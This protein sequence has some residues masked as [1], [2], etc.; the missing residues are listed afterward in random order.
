MTKAPSHWQHLLSTSTPAKVVAIV[1]GWVVLPL[2]TTPIAAAQANNR[3][4]TTEW[5]FDQVDVQ[6]MNL[7]LHRLGLGVPIEMQG[8]VSVD[9]TVSVPW[10]ALTDA[11]SYRI[12]GM[13]RSD[14]LR[15]EKLVIDDF[16][17][18]L[19]LSNGVMSIENLRGR[20]VDGSSKRPITAKGEVTGQANLQLSPLGSIEV[21][22]TTSEIP[23]LPLHD[24]VLAASRTSSEVQIAPTQLAST[25]AQKQLSG[26]ATGSLHFRAPLNQLQN[27]AA[28]TTTANLEINGLS[29][30]GS[31]PL[32]LST[33]AIS[34]D[35]GILTADRM[36]L[37]SP[38][39]AELTATVR[40][41]VELNEQQRFSAAIRSNDLPLGVLSNLFGFDQDRLAKGTL[42]IDA[43]AS[44]TLSRR[45]W[46]ASGRVASP[47]LEVVGVSLGLLEHEFSF[48]H[49]HFRL[50]PA[51]IPNTAEVPERV[52]ES[53]EADY[54]LRDQQW[55]LSKLAACVFGGEVT[56]KATLAL[57][58]LGTHQLDL[59]WSE[60]SPV[61]N[62]N[63]LSLAKVSITGISS[64]EIRWTVPAGQWDLPAKQDGMLEIAVSSIK[65]GGAEVGD[66]RMSVVNRDQ[67]LQ[68][69]AEG[70]LF[71]GDVTVITTAAITEK[72]TW[73]DLMRNPINAR[74]SANSIQLD[75][76][77][78]VLP[79]SVLPDSRYDRLKGRLTAEA[80]LTAPLQSVSSEQVEADLQLRL[81]N[82]A[83]GPVQ[84][85]NGLEISARLRDQIVWID[86]ISGTYA[87]GRIE[88]TGRWDWK[89]Q[90]GP[91]G[92]GRLELRVAAIDA[93]QAM[94]LISKSLAESIDGTLSGNL[95]VTGGEQLRARGAVQTSDAS[96]KGLMLGNVHSGVIA[97]YTV[98]S[99]RWEVGLI[100]I[101]GTL[102]RGRVRGKA[103]FDSAY[104]P[105]RFDM[106]TELG[107][108]RVDFN[109]LIAEAGGGVSTMAQGQ[110][111]GSLVLGGKSIA[112]LSDLRGSF[113][114]ELD[115]SQAAAIP[116]LRDAQRFLGAIPLSGIRIDEGRLN[117]TVSGGR[118][119][120]KE[121]ALASPHLRVWA[122][123]F[124]Q[125]AS[126]RMEVDAVI[127]TGN[128]EANQL[129]DAYLQLVALDF[130]S[131]LALLIRINRLL[132]NR[133]IYVDARGPVSNP[134]LSLKP[135]ATLRDEAVRYILRDLLGLSLAGG[136]EP[137]WE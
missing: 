32:N 20:L 116:G 46:D 137:E 18:T 12:E 80:N 135:L 75:Q 63:L 17:S 96:F 24:L 35:R 53:I 131:P 95:R 65:I 108:D 119:R 45:Q 40:A 49:Q 36:Q 132:S 52:I 99:G 126:G 130:V 16:R 61:F 102:A 56:G 69:S 60:L 31:M 42:D 30:G 67:K 26:L 14:Q 106:Q 87:G 127:S 38:E 81:D 28:W 120:I 55:S 90:A 136:I 15:L 121:F 93:S 84:L 6:T 107:F 118:A 43:R 117:G 113:E 72:T 98:P 33:G 19:D 44:G 86:R 37:T 133:T 4:W 27:I 122:D 7:R 129:A 112:G 1:L 25:D 57:A 70:D 124:V 48:D 11:K 82:V 101:D 92:N 88:A 54:S 13:I 105:G 76:I 79:A 97:S 66:L 62:A 94:Q 128:F 23:I 103:T 41:Q 104:R 8:K 74:V 109:E 89:S 100:S 51:T 110:I 85:T 83:L 50:Q 111:R 22:I 115:G 39:V 59:Q 125:L 3:Y 71:G 134:R 29:R 77:V 64:G 73:Q 5:H 9:L 2:V 68:L 114:T 10:T 34:V 91:V 47:R 78:E 123:G 21:S 58:A